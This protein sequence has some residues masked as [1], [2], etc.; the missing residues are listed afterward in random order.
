MKTILTKAGYMVIGSLLTLI[1]Y[2]FGNIDNNSAD[3]Q[4]RGTPQETEIV[5]E[6]KCRK[7]VIVGKDDT[8]RIILRT[9]LFDHGQIHIYS[10]DILPRV[11][12]GVANNSGSDTGVI[13][14]GQFKITN[15]GDTAVVLGTDDQGRGRLEL[16][17]TLGIGIPDV[18]KLSLGADDNGGFMALWNNGF[19][20]PVVQA[21]ITDRGE[22]FIFTRDKTGNQTGSTGSPGPHI[23]RDK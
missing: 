4:L 13:A 20:K 21:S 17:D 11:S 19:D 12:L 5:D 22:G 3:A 6:I 8:R 10:E 7:L 15:R 2:H 14:T 18:I 1:G 23:I 16:F 9:D